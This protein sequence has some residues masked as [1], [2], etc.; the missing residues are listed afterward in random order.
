MHHQTHRY[1]NQIDECWQNEKAKNRE[2]KH[3]KNTDTEYKTEIEKDI[4]RMNKEAEHSEHHGDGFFDC[5]F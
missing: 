1:M 2:S 5:C 4:Y 3:P